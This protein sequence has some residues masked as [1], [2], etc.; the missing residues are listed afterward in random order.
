VKKLLTGLCAVALSAGLLTACSESRTD[1]VGERPAA[2]TPSA[3]PSTVPPSSPS[4]V[5]PSTATPPADTATPNTN[6]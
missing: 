4:T 6:K 3:S 1:R 5:P 2:G